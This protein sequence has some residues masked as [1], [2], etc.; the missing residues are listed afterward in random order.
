M[1]QALANAKL[2]AESEA[3][4]RFMAEKRPALISA[5]FFIAPLTRLTFDTT[6]DQSERQA[7]FLEIYERA[8]ES[9]ESTPGSNAMRFDEIPARSVLFTYG[10]LKDLTGISNTSDR[11][12]RRKLKVY[13]SGHQSTQIHRSSHS[14]HS[15]PSGDAGSDLYAFLLSVC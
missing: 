3:V 1:I 15:S 5:H 10:R 6:S 13:R 14:S 12:R 9:A 8:M 2:F 7:R 11:C 4:L